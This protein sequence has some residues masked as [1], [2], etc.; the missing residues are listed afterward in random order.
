MRHHHSIAYTFL[1]N[2][3]NID[4]FKLPHESSIVLHSPLLFTLQ[5]L[6]P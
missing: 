2:N 4:P 5:P 1:S 6:Q 3:A